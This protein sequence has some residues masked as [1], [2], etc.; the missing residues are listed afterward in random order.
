MWDL[1]LPLGRTRR[2]ASDLPTI[3]SLFPASQKAHLM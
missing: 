1:E 2:D 3:D